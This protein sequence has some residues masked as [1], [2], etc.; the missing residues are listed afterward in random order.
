[1]PLSR[2]TPM[3]VPVGIRMVWPGLV[4]RGVA[5]TGGVA[6][7]GA[8]LCGPSGVCAAATAARAKVMSAALKMR[9]TWNVFTVGLLMG[10]RCGEDAHRMPGVAVMG[11]LPQNAGRCDLANFGWRS[12]PK[13]CESN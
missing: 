5:G 2:M 3:R 12:H 6:G 10:F 9:W 4:G 1:M 7:G 11:S 8:A 13:L